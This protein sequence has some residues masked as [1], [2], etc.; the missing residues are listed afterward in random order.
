MRGKGYGKILLNN[1]IKE[2]SYENKTAKYLKAKI[3]NNNNKSKKI[4]FN[5]GFKET[6]FIF[7]K[8]SI[9]ELKIL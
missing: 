8:I 9:L 5:N 1:G 4:F 7:N 6:S 3:K 2:F